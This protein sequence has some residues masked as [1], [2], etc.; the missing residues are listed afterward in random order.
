MTEIRYRN[1]EVKSIEIKG[2]ANYNPGNDIVCASCSIL[3][4]TLLNTLEVENIPYTVEEESGYMCIET[5]VNES[6][7]YFKMVHLGYKS[8]AQNY[9]ENVRLIENF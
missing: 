9:P 2:H 4:Y 3:A 7:P 1:D 5:T 8:L 6:E